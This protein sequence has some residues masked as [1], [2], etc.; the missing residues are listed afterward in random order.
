[1]VRIVWLFFLNVPSK[2]DLGFKNLKTR[3]FK[4]LLCSNGAWIMIIKIKMNNCFSEIID[5]RA[6]K[7]MIKELLKVQTWSGSDEGC[8]LITTAHDDV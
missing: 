7:Y 1:M 3:P 4:A 5:K 8:S 6:A 2:K